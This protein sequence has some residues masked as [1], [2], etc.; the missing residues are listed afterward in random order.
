[1]CRLDSI[2]RLLHGQLSGSGRRRK[3]IHNHPLACMGGGVALMQR[4][5]PTSLGG[6]VWAFDTGAAVRDGVSLEVA[7][8]WFL[9]C[10]YW[11]VS[12]RSW[13]D[14]IIRGDENGRGTQR[15]VRYP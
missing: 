13:R 1:M 9:R 14:A 11:L 15:C 8:R 5:W 3:K 7:V 10:C 12:L 4:H 2:G 6:W